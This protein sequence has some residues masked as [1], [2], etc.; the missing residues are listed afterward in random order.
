MNI[1][2][3]FIRRPV[4]AM[5]VSF[6]ILLLGAQGLMSLQVRQYPGG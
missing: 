5:V 4:L 2:E 6:F 1:T 3:L